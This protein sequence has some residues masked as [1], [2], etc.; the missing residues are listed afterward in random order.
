MPRWYREPTGNLFGSVIDA[1]RDYGIVGDDATDNTSALAAMMTDAETDGAMVVL[2]PGT[3]RTDAFP[4]KAGVTVRGMGEAATTLKRTGDGSGAFVKSDGF[5]DLTGDTDTTGAPAHIGLAD[6]TID[7]SYLGDA[8]SHGLAIFGK[9]HTLQGVHIINARGVAYWSEYGTNAN[10]ERIEAFVDRLRCTDFGEGGV[11]HAGPTDSVYGKVITVSS[12]AEADSEDKWHFHNSVWATQVYALHTWGLPGGGL[13]T[14]SP[15]ELHGPQLEPF[16]STG[17]MRCLLLDHGVYDQAAKVFGGVLFCGAG[18]SE[19]ARQK[20]IVLGTNGSVV[21]N[22]VILGTHIDNCGAGAI[23]WTYAGSGGGMIIAHVYEDAATAKSGGPY[24]GTMPAGVTSKIAHETSGGLTEYSVENSY[25]SGVIYGSAADQ[26]SFKVSEYYG[27]ATGDVFR[28]EG[29]WDGSEN[30]VYMSVYPSG[31]QLAS[32]LFQ[33]VGAGSPEGV[34]TA[35]IGSL[36]LRTDGGAST[37][38]YVKESGTGNTGWVA[39]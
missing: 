29:A 26:P 18:S 12:K 11:H 21:N 17:T 38:L 13:Y 36:Y 37:S 34:Y 39:K 28:V 9:L 15:I 19:R 16:C 33:F 24:A 20:G 31:L 14:D 2:P 10:G 30:P 25:A 1:E 23:D 32:G 6:L 35:P 8:D 5:D 3:I 4:A 7:A 22:F 27:G